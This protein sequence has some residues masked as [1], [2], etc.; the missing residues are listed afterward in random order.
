LGRGGL[1]FWG[2][3]QALLKAW[4]AKRNG[5]GEKIGFT[6]LGNGK[7]GRRLERKSTRIGGVGIKVREI[8]RDS[9]CWK[10]GPKCSAVVKKGR[11]AILRE[12]GL[13]RRG[14]SG[15]IKGSLGF[16]KQVYKNNHQVG[17]S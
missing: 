5:G 4:G 3:S 6:V 10:P 2:S 14:G 13:S 1:G 8:V 15:P 9:R 11:W 12:N 7:T 16:L 17:G